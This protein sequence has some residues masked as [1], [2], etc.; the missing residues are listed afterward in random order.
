MTFIEAIQP[1]LTPDNARAY[2]A[3]DEKYLFVCDLIESCD[4]RANEARVNILEDIFDAM[5][6]AA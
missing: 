2:A 4:K 3:T 6:A 5:L 1:I